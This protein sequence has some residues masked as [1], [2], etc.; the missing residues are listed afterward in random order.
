MVPSLPDEEPSDT[1]LSSLLLHCTSATIY[2]CSA[3]M[4]QHP[5]D[6][7]GSESEAAISQ[8]ARVIYMPLMFEK[9][10]TRNG[11]KLETSGQSRWLAKHAFLTHITQILGK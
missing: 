8:D 4:L 9:H 7:P 6:L 11:L 2:R 3:S 1:G 5:Q 10:C